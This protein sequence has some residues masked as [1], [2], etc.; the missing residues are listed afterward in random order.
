V[1]STPLNVCFTLMVIY[2]DSTFLRY[3]SI[4]VGAGG[5]PLR[6]VE[7]VTAEQMNCV[8]TTL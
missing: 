2:D 8:P 6:R 7:L 1:R 4:L 3:L 5:L